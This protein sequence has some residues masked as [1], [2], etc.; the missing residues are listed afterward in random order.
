[1]KKRVQKTVAV[2]VMAFFGFAA[3]FCC[4][5]TRPVQAAQ[6]QMIADMPAY[7]MNQVSGRPACQHQA[8]AA[9]SSTQHQPDCEFCLKHKNFLADSNLKN[10]QLNPT[11]D[12]SLILAALVSGALDLTKN[13]PSTYLSVSPPD[14]S[15]SIPLYLL[16]ANLRI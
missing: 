12:T 13:A 8:K 10:T 1:M 5:G 4:C 14:K 9:S 7:Y 15:S 11:F 3:V 16:H 2:V 6:T